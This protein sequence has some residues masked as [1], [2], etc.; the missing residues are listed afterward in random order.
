MPSPTFQRFMHATVALAL[1]VGVAG[2]VAC[3]STTTGNG[4]GSSGGK[5]TGLFGAGGSGTSGTGG[6]SGTTSGGTASVVPTSC[7]AAA[8]DDMCTACLKSSCCSATL[9]CGSE[10][11][12]KAVFDCAAPCTTQQCTNDCISSHPSA[13]ATLQTFVTCE[14]DFCTTA[15]SGSS[16]TGTSGGTTSG[17]TSG[18]TSTCL[19]GTPQDPSYCPNLPTRQTVEDCPNGPPSSQCVASPTGASGIYCCP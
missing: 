7:S 18:G 1:F 8:S 3:S 12:C 6:T 17:G 15:C 13:R 4:T 2:V 10:P 14:Q 11:E 9:Q 19:A 5:G 16:S